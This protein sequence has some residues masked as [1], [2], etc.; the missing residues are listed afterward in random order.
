MN[1]LYKQ[2]FEFS[3][4]SDLNGFNLNRL[5]TFIEKKQKNDYIEYLLKLA[6]INKKSIPQDLIN[7]IKD[8]EEFYNI[9]YNFNIGLVNGVMEKSE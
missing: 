3:K 7:N 9:V 4:E 2:G 8:D 5:I 1:E 6:V